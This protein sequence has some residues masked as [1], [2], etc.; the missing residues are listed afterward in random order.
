MYKPIEPCKNHQ[1]NHLVSRKGKRKPPIMMANS[2]HWNLD[3]FSC[4]NPMKKAT[5]T[6]RG[7]MTSVFFA[8]WIPTSQLVTCAFVRDERTVQMDA[9]LTSLVMLTSV[10]V[11]MRV[12]RRFQTCFFIAV[13]RGCQKWVVVWYWATAK[14]LQE[15]HSWHVTLWWSSFAMNIDI[16]SLAVIS[17]SSLQC[18]EGLSMKTD[19]G[20]GLA[21]GIYHYDCRVVTPL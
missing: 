19:N 10:A 21:V 1:F 6:V 14:G 5:Q 18:T 13:N 17:R 7:L 16:H 20:F 4:P 3:I 12:Q 2:P 15:V 9:C 8:A 11:G